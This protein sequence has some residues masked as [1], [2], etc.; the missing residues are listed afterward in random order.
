MRKYIGWEA[1]KLL[2]LVLHAMYRQIYPKYS[3]HGR[4]RMINAYLWNRI[5]KLK[6]Y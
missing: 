2:A 3:K 1:L 4:R 5:L 6:V